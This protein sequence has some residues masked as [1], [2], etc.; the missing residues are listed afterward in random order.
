M[1]VKWND[2]NRKIKTLQ[3]DELKH[4]QFYLVIILNI[5]NII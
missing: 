4:E 3:E 2:L 5:Y 1:S